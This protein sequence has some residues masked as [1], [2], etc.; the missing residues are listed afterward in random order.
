MDAV[1]KKRANAVENAA[2]DPEAAL[3][4]DGVL[5]VLGLLAASEQ[6]RAKAEKAWSEFEHRLAASNIPLAQAVQRFRLGRFELQCLMLC[7]SRHIEPRMTTVLGRL[8]QKRLEVGVTVGLAL[9]AFCRGT[10][11]RMEARRAFQPSSQLLRHN[12][13][14]LKESRA[15]GEALSREMDLSPPFLRYVL[16]E[17]GLS[18]DVARVARLERPDVSLLNVVL[19]SKQIEFIRKLVVHHERYREVLGRWGFERVVPYGRGLTLLFAGPSGTGKTLLAQ[20]LAGH[21]GRP[22]LSL[23]AADLPEREGVEALLRDLFTEATMYDA[24]VL[25]DECELLFGRD[26]RRKA[27]AYKVMEDYNGILILVTSRPEVLDEGLG[28]RIVAHIPFEVPDAE[29]R[30]QIWEVHLPDG[31]PIEG[32]LDLDSLATRY[33]YTGG[34]IKN[35]VLVAV[36]LAIARDPEHPRLT[37]D[38]LEEGCQS[39]LRYALEALTERTTTHLRLQD[40]VL[41]EAEKRKVAELIAACRNQTLVLNRWGFG[42]RLVTGKGIVALFDG[43]PGT[44]KTLCAEIVAGELG[45]PLHRVNIPEVV[46]KWVGETEKHIKQ[47]FEAAR[48]SHAIL[49]FDEADALFSGRVAEVRTATDRYANMEVNLL[50]QEIERFPGICILTTN[51]FGL[52][53]KALVRRVQFRVTFREPNAAERLAIWQTLCPQE[54]PLARDVNFEALAERFELTGAQIK[55]ALLR[56]AYRAAEAAKAIDQATLVAACEDECEAAGKVVRSGVSKPQ[57]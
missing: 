29:L 46:S 32:E 45:R 34:T 57:G 17:E 16:G 31:V 44:G 40:I 12:L 7:L 21:L 50:L 24:I 33:D 49:L 26:D 41:P 11:E 9:E 48:V 2:R 23:S 19:P 38:L 15:V 54:A 51:S 6:D 52:L 22:L 55:N 5:A 27:A 4:S 14:V 39:Q 36:N 47:V 53:D 13:I 20:A 25:V 37:Q 28:R 43:P 8:A 35:A 30:R 18:A 56:A 3:L 1:K 42:R 10:L